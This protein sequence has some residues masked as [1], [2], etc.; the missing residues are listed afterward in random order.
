MD[1]HLGRRGWAWTLEAASDVANFITDFTQDLVQNGLVETIL[2]L[3]NSIN[4]VNEASILQK[5][6][7]LGDAKH[8]HQVHDLYLGIQRSLAECIFALA[9]QSGL[10][11]VDIGKL[12]DYLARIRLDQS[13]ADGSLDDV[14]MSLVMAM[15]YAL[16]I[17]RA[18]K[19]NVDSHD[20]LPILSDNSFVSSIHRELS[21]SN[22]SRQWNHDGILALA[23]YAWAMT[24]ATIRSQPSAI[25]AFSMEQQQV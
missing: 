19:G 24:L 22:S 16:D 12:F 15:L 3:L 20:M 6:M 21:S 14:T 10:G 13:N 11:R 23:R 8:R 25:S 7:A 5:N 9:A 17:A 1:K 4:W 2:E 18:L